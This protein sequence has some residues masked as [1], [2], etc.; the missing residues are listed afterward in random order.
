MSL[1]RIISLLIFAL[2]HGITYAQIEV[3]DEQVEVEVNASK[4][5]EGD[6]PDSLLVKKHS[7]KKAALFSAVLPGAGQIYNKKYWKL[8][9]VYGA[10]LGMVYL[11]VNNY[12][13]YETYRETYISRVDTNSNATDHFPFMSNSGVQSEIERYQKNYELAAIGVVLVYVLQIVDATVDAHLYTFDV[14]D[15]LSMS[16]KP[17]VMSN[18]FELSRG[19]IPTVGLSLNL[20]LK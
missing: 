19:R 20:R 13:N 16:V 8:P 10:G 15:D 2:L 5:I 3:E 4:T 9:I 1:I 18:P 7:P 12:R 14:S 6:I 11:L 17:K